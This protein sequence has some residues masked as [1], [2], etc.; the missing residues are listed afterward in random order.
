MYS[1]FSFVILASMIAGSVSAQQVQS[2]R[3][4]ASSQT[5]PIIVN[6]EPAPE[7]K[8]VCRSFVP[9]GSVMP[10]RTCKTQ[11]QWEDERQA[12]LTLRDSL[13]K[14]QELTRMVHM[15]LCAVAPERCNN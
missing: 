7:D 10:Q 11:A 5:R 12:G 1:A 14:Q 8:K 15:Q 9:T 6:G 13:Q 3:P 4:Q 2:S